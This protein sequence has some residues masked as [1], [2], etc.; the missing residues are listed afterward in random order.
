MPTAPGRPLGPV[1]GCYP[2]PPPSQCCCQTNFLTRPTKERFRK[3]QVIDWH[4]KAIILSWVTPSRWVVG[5]PLLNGT[6]TYQVQ[7]AKVVQTALKE[8]LSMSR[9]RPMTLLGCVAGQS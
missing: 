8:D 4:H 6:G 2:P 9:Q 5:A 3:K 1:H 7:A